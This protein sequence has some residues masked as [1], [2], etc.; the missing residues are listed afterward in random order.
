MNKSKRT[1]KGLSLLNHPSLQM[2]SLLTKLKNWD[3]NNKKNIYNDEKNKYDTDDYPVSS[4]NKS[5]VS[6]NSTRIEDQYLSFFMNN[7]ILSFCAQNHDLEMLKIAMKLACDKAFCKSIALRCINWFMRQSTELNCIHDLLSTITYSLALNPSEMKNLQNQ[8]TEKKESELDYDIVLKH[9]INDIVLAGCHAQG[10]VEDFHELYQSISDLMMSI[11][12]SSP[13]LLTAIRCWSLQFQQSDHD[14]LHR[15]H[16]F[17]NISKILSRSENVED[18]NK[19]KT[20]KSIKLQV[21]SDITM[22]C[23]IEASSHQQMTSCL[24]D[25]TTE[26]FWESGDDDR[27][28]SKNLFI[29][30]PNQINLRVLCVHID[31]VRDCNNK[32]YLVTLN[33]GNNM[34]DL[35]MCGKV[36]VENTYV[37]WISMCIRNQDPFLKVNFKGPD[38]SLRIRQI[39]LLGDEPGDDSIC[40][41]E[42]SSQSIQFKNCESE[43]LKVFK[44]L[45]SQVFGNLLQNDKK[46]SD[47]SDD[48]R[49]LKEHVVGI[50]F[51]Q[52]NLSTMQR[53]VCSYILKAIQKETNNFKI[54]LSSPSMHACQ[55]L[56]DIYIFEL[57]SLVL[58][59]S[60][61]KVGCLFIAQQKNLINDLMLLLH[62]SSPRVQRQVV[63]LLRRLLFHMEPKHFSD[64]KRIPCFLVGK[65]FELIKT[66]LIDETNNGHKGLFDVLLLCIVKSL[67]L[68]IKVPKSDKSPF[69]PNETYTFKSF[70]KEQFMSSIGSLWLSDS[71]SSQLAESII[72]LIRDLSEGNITNKWSCCIKDAISENILHFSS[73]PEHLRSPRE[74]LKDIRLWMTL[75]SLCV[76]SEEHTKLLTSNNLNKA[77][78]SNKKILCANHD[79]DETTAVISCIECGSLCSECDRILHL[80]KKTKC[81]KRQVFREEK[82]YLKVDCH[83]G[84]GRIKLFWLLALADSRNLKV[85]VEFRDVIKETKLTNSTSGMLLLK[86]EKCRF[87][88]TP[89]D[90]FEGHTNVVCGQEECLELLNIACKN[91]LKC[92]HVC[93]GIRDESECLPCLHGCD[94]NEETGL[95][96]DADDMCMICFTDALSKAPTIQL[97]CQHVF[98]FQCCQQ[99]LFSKWPGPRITFNF[100]LCPI[101]KADIEH[102]SLREILTPLK[103]RR[104]DVKNKAL[105]RLEF[106]GLVNN[107]SIVTPGSAFYKDP[108]S[109][110]INRYAYYVCSKCDKAYYGGEARCEEQM[111]Y[112][113]A[114]NFDASELLCGGCSDINMAQICPKHGTD[115]LEYKCRYCCSV[116]VFFCFGTTHFCNACHDDFQRITSISFSNL[117]Q[118]PVGSRARQL[119]GEDCPLNVEHPATGKEFALGCGICRNSHTF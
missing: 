21:L 78:S 13:L 79:D 66:S 100:M 56:N 18:K 20:Q 24:T 71:I 83:E 2:E 38:S 108:E 25:K 67:V 29:T 109:Y 119:E 97:A 117:P 88:D 51:S 85:I 49:N 106:E 114:D 111:V 15:S 35:K 32:I 63:L 107:H 55:C 50:L 37:G 101:C 77:E 73:L 65:K 68:Q 12:P 105:M 93:G 34:E 53:Q 46:N 17:K 69:K 26:T 75:A 74:C 103:N 44:L 113:H 118:C 96:Q 81:H 72:S 19:I 30:M 48:K 3:D 31:N 1:V 76:L 92:G 7:E 41:I 45:T 91:V 57:L 84:C 23:D 10:V 112:Q 82:E 4:D 99:V 102:E 59:L 40:K 36:E 98:H 94:S 11:P 90:L 62:I 6:N 27:N 110:A 33:S 116:A 64:L 47:D 16:V 115:F 87:C 86:K 22:M 39:K 54:N 58:A 89:C 104:F 61:S 42:A 28:R 14:F 52:I 5:N 8:T 80:S 60:G 95:K 43:T 9:P 70:L